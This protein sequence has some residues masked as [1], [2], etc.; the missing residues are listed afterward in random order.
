M[1]AN[2]LALL[3][4]RLGLGINM[5]MHGLV[6]IPKLGAFVAKTETGFA[7]TIL[8]PMLTKTFLFTLPF[9]EL[10]V[11][12]LILVGGQFSKWGYFLGGLT[13]SALLFGTT[14]KEDWTT[15]GTQL[16]YIIAFYLALNGLEESGRNRFR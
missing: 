7:Q 3:V 6:R 5:L 12:L 14:L 4:I 16:I 15:A 10:T 9:V 11:G 2:T 1:N 13:V 8:P